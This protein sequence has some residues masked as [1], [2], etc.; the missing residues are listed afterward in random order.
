MIP[1]KNRF[2]IL[3]REPSKKSPFSHGKPSLVKPKKKLRLIH[4][5]DVYNIEP[6]DEDPVGGAARF[7]TVLKALQEDEK[8]LVVFSGD[9]FSPSKCRFWNQNLRSLLR[10]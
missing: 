5:N 10:L 7:A 3:K 6:S 2:V 4:F 8:A 9:A 1:I